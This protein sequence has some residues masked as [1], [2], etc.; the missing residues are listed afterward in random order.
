MIRAE[1]TARILR[2]AGLE[3]QIAAAVA[4]LE[5]PSADALSDAIRQ[6]FE[7]APE[8]EWRVHVHEVV[9]DTDRDTG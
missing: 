3:D 2:E 8:T 7:R 6:G 9:N 1:I 4:T 5:R